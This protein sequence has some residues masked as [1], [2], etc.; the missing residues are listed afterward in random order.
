MSCFV[1]QSSLLS[2]V[3][4]RK[5]RDGSASISICII[6]RATYTYQKRM[7]T[8]QIQRRDH[9]MC[10]T[11]SNNTSNRTSRKIRPRKQLNLLCRLESLQ[12]IR[13]RHCARSLISF[14]AHEALFQTLVACA[15]LRQRISA[16]A[17][18]A[19]AI[20]TSPQ[21]PEPNSQSRG[22]INR[23]EYVSY[24]ALQSIYLVLLSNNERI[25][26]TSVPIKL[27]AMTSSA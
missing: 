1:T 18:Y 4:M 26:A 24:R 21:A 15:V 6:S 11:T 22:R 2:H 25:P 13:R 10:R 17:R 3:P 16:N 9:G 7:K 20:G 12:F 23:G 8:H 19:I 5:C 27:H 14:A